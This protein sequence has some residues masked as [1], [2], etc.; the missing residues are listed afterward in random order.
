MVKLELFHKQKDAVL[1]S[2][3]TMQQPKPEEEAKGEENLLNEDKAK[4]MIA[5]SL[6][7]FLTEFA[8]MQ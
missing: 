2:H 8:K 3:R 7:N 4:N 1:V 5:S 6:D